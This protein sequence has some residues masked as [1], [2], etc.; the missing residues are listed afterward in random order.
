MDAHGLARL[1]RFGHD[2]VQ[3]RTADASVAVGGGRTMSTR[4]MSWRRASP[5]HAQR[6]HPYLPCDYAANTAS[7]VGAL[8]TRSLQPNSV[9]A[10]AAV[11]R[12]AHAPGTGP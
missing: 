9:S 3:Q 8:K 2:R 5:R 12:P 7:R 1:G 10:P 6:D 11:T 4:H